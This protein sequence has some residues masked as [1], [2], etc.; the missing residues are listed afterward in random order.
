MIKSNE[1]L[2][3]MQEKESVM[4]LVCIEKSVPRDHCLA[5]LNKPG[6]AKQ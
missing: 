4:T 1:K 6:D 2:K 5:S 3:S